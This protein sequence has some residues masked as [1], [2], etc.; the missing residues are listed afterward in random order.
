ML[1]IKQL[2]L[3]VQDGPAADCLRAT[4]MPCCYFS[5]PVSQGC[6]PR[7]CAHLQAA[8]RPSPAKRKKALPEPTP[9]KAQQRLAARERARQA[10]AG[11]Q[12][13]AYQ[14]IAEQARGCACH[15]SIISAALPTRCCS[16]PTTEHAC[17]ILHASACAIQ[18]P[19]L[20]TLFGLPSICRWWMRWLGR[21]QRQLRTGGWCRCGP[22]SRW[23]GSRRCMPRSGRQVGGVGG[24]YI[25][26]GAE[27]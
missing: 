6:C 12:P 23:R 2:L 16:A 9:T 8:P 27:K 19:T 18:L 26:C 1:R 11:S 15:G 24:T 21:R 10:L 13:D 25:A 22:T 20:P 17:R 3:C 4:G 14:L 7:P 5:C